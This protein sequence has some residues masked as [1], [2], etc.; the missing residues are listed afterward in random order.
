[1]IATWN[2]SALWLWDAATGVPR[3][4][5]AS[6][7]GDGG[8]QLWDADMPRWSELKHPGIRAV[9]IG[10][11]GKMIATAEFHSA[12]LWDA[13]TG[14]SRGRD[15]HH[16]GI[17]AAAFSPDGRTIATW[18]GDGARLWDTDTHEPIG[19]PKHH[20]GIR[21]LAF[22]PDGKAIVMTSSDDAQLWPM[23]PRIEGEV[24][25]IL[26][27]SQVITGMELDR[28]GVARV[29]DAPTWRQRLEEL[30]GPPM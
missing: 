26:L 4:G 21:D 29:L 5:G 11:S 6:I 8:A 3:G 18:G 13:A 22:S 28:S 27:W 15:L 17:R 25:R 2:D 1:M 14:V 24:E 16:P 20:L 7:P 19:L 10:P 30:G 23:P 12:R 9:A